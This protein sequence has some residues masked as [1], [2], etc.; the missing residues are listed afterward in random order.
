MGLLKRRRPVPP[1]AANPRRQS[2][3]LKYQD[4]DSITEPPCM[5]CTG[6]KRGQ[7][8]SNRFTRG[9]SKSPS[10]RI[11]IR[12]DSSKLPFPDSFRNYFT[13]KPITGIGTDR[14]GLF[15]KKQVIF[16]EIW[17]QYRSADD[18]HAYTRVKVLYAVFSITDLGILYR[19][20]QFST[21]QIAGKYLTHC[22]AVAL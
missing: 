8:I 1:T 19:F 16:S 12:S 5:P 2:D 17:Q 22:R 18:Y 13:L 14:Q 10:Q 21:K 7:V 15:L 3:F 20:E 11:A 6:T 4:I 9:T